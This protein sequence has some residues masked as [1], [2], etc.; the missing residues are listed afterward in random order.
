MVDTSYY[1]TIN[2]RISLYTELCVRRDVTFETM[3]VVNGRYGGL[4]VGRNGLIFICS[5]DCQKIQ[6]F[7]PEGGKA[8]REIPCHGFEQWEM[9]LMTSS[10]AIVVQNICTSSYQCHVHVINDVSGAII[11]SISKDGDIPY[12]TVCQDDSVIIA[13]VKL[14]CQGLLSIV[15][16]T[17]KL[18]YITSILTDFK[19]SKSYYGFLQAFKTGEIAFCTNN[20]LYIFHE[21]WD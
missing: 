20:R 17:K 11:H 9:F 4:T 1:A 14:R 21:T 8:I 2:N 16:Y 7:K 6:V 3:D 12:P 13:W 18:K 15:Q 10:Q 5:S 19:I